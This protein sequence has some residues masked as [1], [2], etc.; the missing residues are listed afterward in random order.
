MKTFVTVSKHLE[1]IGF[2]EHQKRFNR[3]QLEFGLN[4]VL[5]IILI[6]LNLF[7]VADTSEEYMNGILIGVVSTL[8]F[9]AFVSTAFKTATI[10]IF[11]NQ[12]NGI[13]NQSEYETLFNLIALQSIRLH[14]CE[15]I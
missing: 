6:I 10:F 8:L 5:G 14:N 11:I 3:R 12:L 9:I 7:Y 13:I 4:I 15:K 2:T 1:S